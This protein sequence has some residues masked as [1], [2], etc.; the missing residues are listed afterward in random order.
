MA[1]NDG[2]RQVAPTPEGIRRD[3]T[4]RYE[5]AARA[6][7][8]GSRVIDLACGV[9][10]GARILAE[11]GHTVLAVDKDKEAIAYAQEH[12]QHPRVTHLAA[13]AGQFSMLQYDAAVCF[14]TLEHLEDPENLLE[15]FSAKRLLLIAS[16]PNEEKFPYRN[17]TFHHRHYTRKEFGE[18]LAGASFKVRSWHGQADHLSEVEDNRNGRTVIVIADASTETAIENIPPKTGPEHVAIIGLGSSL[19]DYVLK[20]RQLGS[21]HAFCDEVW[22]INALGDILQSDR[23]FHMDDVRIQE[24]RAALFPNGHVARMMQWLKKHP[25]PIYTSRL[26]PDYPGL[27][28]FPLQE[29]LNNGGFSY[30]NNTA[31]YAIAYAIHIGVKTIS[32]FGLDFTRANVHTAEQGR[33]CCEFWLGIAAARGMVIYCPENTSLMDACV[34][35]SH[36]PYGYDCVEVLIEDDTHGKAKVTFKDREIIPTAQEIEK[37]YDHSKHPNPLISG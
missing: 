22:T 12:Y 2:E 7:P 6:L 4:A 16:V 34:P 3:H 13:A 24:Q 28:E 15:E 17:Y 32:L 26:H 20:V 14:E 21:R 11:A 9:G 37:R 29:V 30:F 35:E 8:P 19:N 5:F 23:I 27:V 36:K 31:A 10:Y 18:L 25:G 1:L 33:A